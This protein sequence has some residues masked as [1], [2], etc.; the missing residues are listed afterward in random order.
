MLVRADDEERRRGTPAQGERDSGSWAPF[1]MRPLP[2]RELAGK[3]RGR[4]MPA[5]GTKKHAVMSI[6]ESKHV[7]RAAMEGVILQGGDQGRDSGG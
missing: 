2:E 6:T 4:N 1:M 5:E 3:G 7:I